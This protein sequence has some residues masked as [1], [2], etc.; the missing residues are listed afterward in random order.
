M[1]VYNDQQQIRAHHV[2]KSQ[3]GFER[4]VLYPFT[5]RISLFW[6][7]RHHCSLNLPLVLFSL[8]L[9]W[10]A[11]LWILRAP[12]I[13]LCVCPPVVCLTSDDK[14]ITNLYEMSIYILRWSEQY[15]QICL[16]NKTAGHKI[17]TG[18]QQL[19]DLE[20]IFHCLYDLS[21]YLL[22]HRTGE[23]WGLR[24]RWEYCVQP[25]WQANRSLGTRTPRLPPRACSSS[26]AWH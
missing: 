23:A 18:N 13:F 20:D 9:L 22:P 25:T 2:N 19:V 21:K 1:T 26:S 8:G 24:S 6:W 10:T 4:F 5:L 16:D 12:R 7:I 11:S 3:L 14:S 15:L 17:G